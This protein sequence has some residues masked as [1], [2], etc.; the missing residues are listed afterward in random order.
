MSIAEVSEK[1]R[2]KKIKATDL[3]ETSLNKLSQK[4]DYDLV[5]STLEER[6]RARAAKVDQNPRGRLAGVPFIAKDNFLTFGGKTTAASNI[7][8]PFEAPY[9]STAVERLEAEGAI[10]IAKSNM[11]AFA[12]GSSTENSDW[13]VTK[14]PSDKTR[15][16]G[17]SSGGS[18]ASVA[19][20]IVPFAIGTDTG[21]SIREPASFCGVVGYKPTY[22]LVSRS[23]VVA[24]ASS[25][26][27]IGPLAKTVE[28]AAIVLDVMSGKDK[29]DGTTIEKDIETYVDLDF[30]IKGK[31]FGVIKEYFG[32]GMEPGVESIIKDSID[33][34]KDAGAQIE[35][36]SLPSA[37]LA[38]AVYYIVCP[39]EVSSN[40]SRYDGQR[41]GYSSP[42][43]KNLDESYELSREQGFGAEAKRRIMIGTHVLSSGYYDAYYKKAQIV[44]TK[45]INEFKT[46]FESQDFLIGPV[47][48]MTA[49]KIGAKTADPLQMY[50]CDIMT[51][52]AN[53]TGNPAI[54]VPA[55]VTD[56]LPV[57]LQIIGRM[58]GDRDL[59][60]IAKAFEEIRE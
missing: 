44:R 35:E 33:K 43:A 41:Y 21:G 31:K 28:D 45:L 48:P 53:I 51:V 6:A 4:K 27:V 37:P 14:H 50:L 8:R 60:G 30:K 55:G 25:T 46:V 3:V 2:S 52:A 42:D 39:A 57:G 17:G 1:V 54:S 29:L 34:L 24:M 20:D 22:G 23:G 38:L 59:L 19:L 9:Q 18:A 47:A 16:P 49:F 40:L 11:D 5:I 58:Q 26:D 15:V 13:F 12:H 10:C 56:G 36:I 32:Q 7:L